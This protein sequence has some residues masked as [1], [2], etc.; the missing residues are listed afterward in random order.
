M[1]GLQKD[2][3]RRICR[4]RGYY[5]R[6]YDI[7]IGLSEPRAAR[8]CSSTAVMNVADSSPRETSGQ[9]KAVCQAWTKGPLPVSWPRDIL[10]GI[11]AP[12]EGRNSPAG[13]THRHVSY[14]GD[15]QRAGLSQGGDVGCAARAGPVTDA[16]AV[17]AQMPPLEASGACPYARPG[18]SHGRAAPLRAALPGAP[19]VLPSPPLRAA[20]WPRPAQ[21]QRSA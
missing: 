16:S 11:S 20:Q 9:V 12:G 7:E 18:Q 5:W 4:R 6:G 15:N 10:P 1:T 21:S 14:C 8:E 3:T 17:G 2:L 19:A 13:N